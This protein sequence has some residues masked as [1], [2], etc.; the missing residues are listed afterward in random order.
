MSGVPLVGK[1]INSTKIN[2]HFYIYTISNLTLT[3]GNIYINQIIGKNIN[4]RKPM[5]KNVKRR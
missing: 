1:N 4:S 2:A 5:D 3:N